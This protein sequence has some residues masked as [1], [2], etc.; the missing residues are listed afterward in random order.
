VF[1]HDDELVITA[2]NGPGVVVVLK[3]TLPSHTPKQVG[4]EVLS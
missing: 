3:T 1:G 2:V 4:Y